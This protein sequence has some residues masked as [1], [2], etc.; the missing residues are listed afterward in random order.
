MQSPPKNPSRRT[1]AKLEEPFRD[2]ATRLGFTSLDVEF[3]V[4]TRDARLVHIWDGSA[5]RSQF[6]WAWTGPGRISP[7]DPPSA[8]SVRSP[9]AV[10]SI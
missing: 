9:S 1:F 6:R 2:C 3:P 8:Q 10:A 5:L 4:A 7:R